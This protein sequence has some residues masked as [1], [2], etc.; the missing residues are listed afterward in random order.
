MSHHLRGPRGPKPPPRVRKRCTSPGA[1]ALLSLMR[2]EAGPLLRMLVPDINR[3]RKA[4]R[5]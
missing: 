5:R 3:T 2:R 1:I 4:A